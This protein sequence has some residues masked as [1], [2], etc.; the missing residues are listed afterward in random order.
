MLICDTVLK[1]LPQCFKLAQ[2]HK[3]KGQ[4]YLLILRLLPVPWRCDYLVSFR[5]LHRSFLWDV[6]RIFR[7]RVKGQLRSGRLTDAWRTQRFVDWI[8]WSSRIS[9]FDRQ[10]WTVKTVRKVCIRSWE[11]L[12]QHEV[13]RLVQDLEIIILLVSIYCRFTVFWRFD[14]CSNPGVC[15]I[16]QHFLHMAGIFDC[17]C[18]PNLAYAGKS[19]NIPKESFEQIFEFTTGK[20]RC[21]HVQQIRSSSDQVACFN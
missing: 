8:F 10:R 13:P 11:G 15:D 7:N 12:F 1:Y 4:T 21:L 19:P 18:N 9:G 14:E 6:L 2:E 3:W 17:L 5:S 20:R 16:L